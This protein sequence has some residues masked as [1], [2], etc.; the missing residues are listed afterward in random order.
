MHL[1]QYVKSEINTSYSI[2]VPVNSHPSDENAQKERN[3]EE[4]NLHLLRRKKDFSVNEEI[5]R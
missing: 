5:G 1:L 3:W 2:C 4:G